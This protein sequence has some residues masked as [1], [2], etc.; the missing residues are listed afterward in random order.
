MANL[1]QEEITKLAREDA[2]EVLARSSAFQTMS[3]ADQMSTY[4]DMV[5]ANAK[6]LS[7][8]QLLGGL[9]G[10]GISNKILNKRGSQTA[11]RA[12]DLINDN[13][14]KIDMSRSVEA[15]DD[16]VDTVNFPQFVKDL[17]KGV[18]D[19][20]MSVMKEQTDSFIK[21]M[22]EASKSVAQFV[23]Q[24]S[25][26]D[27]FGELADNGDDF[28][29]SFDEEGAKLTNNDGE[30]VDMEDNEVKV[31]I[32]DAKLKLAK[33]H[34]K[35]L[36][37]IML[38]GVNRIVIDKG[39]IKAGVQFDFKSTSNNDFA[40]KAMN[41]N[42][43][44]TGSYGKA[45]GG[46]IGSIFGGPSGGR[47]K[48][49]RSTSLSVSSAKSKNADEMATKLSGNVQ[50]DFKTDYFELDKFADIYKIESDTE[51]ATTPGAT[52]PAPAPAPSP[53]R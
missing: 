10:G 53:T 12:G 24:V 49:S 9:V 51:I 41:K 45:S 25:D 47:S 11:D 37:E 5:R 3:K 40:D 13:R 50:I 17:V 30:P 43:S 23:K 8:Q 1:S 35:A 46:L 20:N 7:E 21:L 6:R 29:M 16:L 18:F 39:T 44:S 32:M 33:E 27:A 19:A 2:K 31:A 26:E 38:M 36:R 48:S 22:K 42:S 34:R 15:F 28:N 4:K 14:H 52:P